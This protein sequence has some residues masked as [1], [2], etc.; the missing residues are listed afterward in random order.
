[1]EER[2]DRTSYP[3]LQIQS[4]DQNLDEL[5]ATS[6]HTYRSQLAIAQLDRPPPSLSLC[7]RFHP[8]FLFDR[9]LRLSQTINHSI[10]PKI[11]HL[12]TS[13][14]PFFAP[15]SIYLHTLARFNVFPHPIPV[16]EP[17]PISLAP[18]LITSPEVDVPTYLLKRAFDSASETLS[19]SV[20][21]AI[22]HS[23]P[24]L[25]YLLCSFNAP[26]SAA[27]FLK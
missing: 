26:P 3:S 8:L 6:E 23:R 27:P 11:S 15:S 25:P 1:M 2:S 10:H 21:P 22:S 14:W 4:F 20:A 24:R 19:A 13:N 16:L 12:H 18:S 9:T 17:V 7:G 5:Y